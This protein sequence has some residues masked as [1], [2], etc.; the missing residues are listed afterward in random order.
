MASRGAAYEKCY[1]EATTDALKRTLRH[2]GNLLGS[3]VYD[4]QFLRDIKK[5]KSMPTRFEPDELCRPPEVITDPPPALASKVKKEFQEP[6]SAPAQEP[7]LNPKPPRTESVISRNSEEYG[8][9]ELDNLEFDEY[10]EVLG[11]FDLHEQTV[12]GRT[13]SESNGQH[14][15]SG[16]Q[17]VESP[18]FP[19]FMNARAAAAAAHAHSANTNTNMCAAQEKGQKLNG[20]MQES[21]KFNHHAP[22]SPSMK[23]KMKL[24]THDRSRAVTRT[25]LVLETSISDSNLN[26]TNLYADPI[27]HGT[28]NNNIN[29]NK[30][31]LAETTM[32]VVNQANQNKIQRTKQ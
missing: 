22:F 15:Y 26:E 11:D 1:K 23:H 20:D 18:E 16:P 7:A 24:A 30:R 2:F 8:G 27:T 19:V 6:L 25:G 14:I 3:C 32:K 29:F 4:K 28:N 21:Y 31:V 13:S 12:I 10:H 9:E 17:R 5:V